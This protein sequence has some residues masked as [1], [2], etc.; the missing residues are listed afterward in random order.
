MRR[1]E[2]LGVAGLG[3][4]SA[5]MFAKQAIAQHPHH[6]DKSTA[7][8]SRHARPAPRFATRRSTI[9]SARSRTVMPNI[10]APPS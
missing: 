3:L 9:L 6:H 8:A 5:T 4:A 2:I 7:N 1:R 10:I